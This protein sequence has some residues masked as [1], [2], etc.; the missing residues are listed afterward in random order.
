L[1]DS[2]KFKILNFK[3]CFSQCAPAMYDVGGIIQITT[4][5]QRARGQGLG[6][7]CT[8]TVGWLMMIALPAVAHSPPGP[9]CRAPCR[10]SAG[11]A[12]A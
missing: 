12:A 5:T 8:R 3:L 7:P 4:R 10:R 6:A 2:I 11:M 1:A 9:P